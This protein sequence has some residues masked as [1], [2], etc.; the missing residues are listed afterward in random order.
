MTELVVLELELELPLP[1]DE[2]LLDD[3][4]PAERAR[5]PM[6]LKVTVKASLR[7][8]LKRR[9][10]AAEVSFAVRVLSAPSLVL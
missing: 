9:F 3:P 2:L 6:T 10:R 1:P 4:P 5:F 7:G 8:L